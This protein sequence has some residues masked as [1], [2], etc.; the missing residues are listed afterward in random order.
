MKVLVKFQEEPNIITGNLEGTIDAFMEKKQIELEKIEFENQG[1][2]RLKSLC[3]GRSKAIKIR[4]DGQKQRFSN[5]CS[6]TSV[7]FL[8]EL[9]KDEIKSVVLEKNN[10]ERREEYILE[11]LLAFLISQ[12]LN[13][14]KKLI[15]FELIFSHKTENFCSRPLWKMASLYLSKNVNPISKK[16]RNCK[17]FVILRGCQVSNAGKKS[18]IHRRVQ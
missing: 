16:Y 15:V 5:E 7:N 8:I 3:A 6:D 12:D 2:S 10:F 11:T 17:Y 13:A 4:L 18:M 14:R 1:M 9:L